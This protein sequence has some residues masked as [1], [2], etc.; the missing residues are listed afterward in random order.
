[1]GLSGLKELGGLVRY[2]LSCF[3]PEWTRVSLRPVLMCLVSS[4]TALPHS[5]CQRGPKCG[6]YVPLPRTLRSGPSDPPKPLFGCKE[7][8]KPLFRSR[9]CP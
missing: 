4:R 1:M 7:T 3:R 9:S 5:D 6:L 8:S 2:W